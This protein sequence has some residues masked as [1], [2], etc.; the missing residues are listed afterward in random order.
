MVPSL[1]LRHW[2]KH[3]RILYQ[4]FCVSGSPI[5]GRH[6]ADSVVAKLLADVLAPRVSDPAPVSTTIRTCVA[7][8]LPYYPRI[9]I[10]LT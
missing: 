8:S 6:N 2:S 7:V 4:S 1:A 3:S 9:E 5:R 10:K